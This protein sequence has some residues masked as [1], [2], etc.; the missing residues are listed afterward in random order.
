M[1]KLLYSCSVISV[2]SLALIACKKDPNDSSIDKGKQQTVYTEQ[3]I[4][5]DIDGDGNTDKTIGVSDNNLNVESAPDGSSFIREESGTDQKYC[6]KNLEFYCD[7]NGGMYTQPTA[8]N[9][10][11]ENI[12]EEYTQKQQES[13]DLA[14]N[15]QETGNFMGIAGSGDG[16]IDETGEP[17]KGIQG[18]CPDGW[19]IPSDAE[20][21]ELELAM[22]MSQEDAKLYGPEHDRG[23]EVNLRDQFVEKLGLDYYG[24]Y[25]S[26]GKYSQLDEAGVFASSTP[27]MKNDTIYLIARQIDTLSHQG[28]VRVLLDKPT[29]ISIRCFKD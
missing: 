23:A 3:K 22:G 8:L 10:T 14:G 24:Y 11:L 27:V 29:G 28:V 21:T 13:G 16:F 18:I 2:C 15:E 26:N 5:L 20:W 19:H 6:Y 12:Y 25:A 7:E 1:R 17:I 4:D 9:N